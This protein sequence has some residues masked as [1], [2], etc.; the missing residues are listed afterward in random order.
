MANL[1]DVRRLKLGPSSRLDEL[2]IAAG[3]LYSA[4]LVFFWR[5]VRRKGVWLSPHAMMRLFNS[6]EL[7]AHSADAVVQSFYAALKSWRKRRKSDPDAKPPGR[8]RKFFKVQWKTGSFRLRDGILILSNGKGNSPLEIPWQWNLPKLVEIGWDGAQYELRAVYVIQPSAKP[9]GTKVAGID[10]GEVHLAT[11]HDGERCTILNGRELRSKKRYQNKVKA[12]LSALIDR[13]KKGSR[14]RKRLARSKA[15]QLN[16]V[17]NQVRE[18]LHKQTTHLVST[19]YQSG[20]Q[21]VVIGDV[22]D[23]RQGLDYG[24]K[25]NQK[26]HQMHHGAARHYITYKAQRL[27]IDVVLQEERYTSQTCPAC[28]CRKKPNGRE[29]RCKCGFAYHRDGVG[30]LNIRAKYLGDFG[31]PVVGVM[32]PPTGLR[33]RPHTRVARG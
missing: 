10:L 4:T 18:V 27:G 21:T 8:R 7:H 28:A 13:K 25:A 16:R 3:C 5:V 2:A 24:A 31:S 32:A 29:Y 22:R 23:I 15:K 1:Y 11:A 30:A 6:K 14:R 26:L 17:H 20:V 12:R 9:I 33:F 19:L